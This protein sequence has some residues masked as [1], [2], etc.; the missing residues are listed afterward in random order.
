M[1]LGPRA[2]VSGVRRAAY[3]EKRRQWRAHRRRPVSGTR[4]RLADKDQIESTV[5][6][7]L[8]LC[9]L[10]DV[11]TSGSDGPDGGELGPSIPRLWPTLLFPPSASSPTLALVLLLLLRRQ[12]ENLLLE[13]REDGRLRPPLWESSVF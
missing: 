2:R 5:S 10:V 9:S 11:V 4:S 6:R 8:T 1:K 13:G 12:P 3:E 7:Y